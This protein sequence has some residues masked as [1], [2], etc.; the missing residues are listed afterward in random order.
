VLGLFNLSQNLTEERLR[1]LLEKYGKL[2]SIIL[3]KDRMVTHS[4]QHNTHTHTHRRGLSRL[5]SRRS[6]A[7]LDVVCVGA[8]RTVEGLLLCLL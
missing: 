3:I 6:P 8:D 2:K 7:V 5:L 1:E 4:A